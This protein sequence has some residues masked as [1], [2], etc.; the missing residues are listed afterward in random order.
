MLSGRTLA[1]PNDDSSEADPEYHEPIKQK[2]R[3]KKSTKRQKVAEDAMDVDGNGPPKTR[4]G[5]NRRSAAE[6]TDVNVDD[7][8]DVDSQSGGCGRNPF[9]S[10]EGPGDLIDVRM[11]PKDGIVSERDGI[12]S[13]GDDL[14]SDGNGLP[15]DG[16]GVT[17]DRDGVTSDGDGLSSAVDNFGDATTGS[18]GLD[19]F[20]D[21]VHGALGY[22]PRCMLSHSVIFSL[23]HEISSA[24]SRLQE[25][26]STPLRPQVGTR[27][28]Q[29]FIIGRYLSIR[30][31]I[32]PIHCHIQIVLR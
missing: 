11:V 23:T 15:S 27:R 21:E 7:K 16:D 3:E 18:E 24:S 8:M 32:L 31:R 19:F 10:V 14:I 4:T 12:A 20:T 2:K 5:K 29:T 17:S 1:N 28:R 9:Q 25:L 13:D 26:P 6:V 30:N 22:E